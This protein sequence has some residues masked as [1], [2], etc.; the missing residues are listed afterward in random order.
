MHIWQCLEKGWDD[1]NE[2]WVPG[3]G[4]HLRERD[5]FSLYMI[6]VYGQL[7]LGMNLN[8]NVYYLY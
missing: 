7:E 1:V 4:E 3:G 6:E 5:L 2:W 8:K